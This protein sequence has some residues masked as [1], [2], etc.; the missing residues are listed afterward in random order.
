MIGGDGDASGAIIASLQ[1][2]PVKITGGGEL[3][4]G[5]GINAGSIISKSG[6]ISSVSVDGR[7]L[8]ASGVSG[9]SGIIYAPSGTVKSVH[10]GADLVGGSTGAGEAGFM[11]G[12]IIGENIGTV[13]IDGSLI[14]GHKDGGLGLAGS[15]AIMANHHLESVSIGGNVL[16]N[17]DNFALISAV[18]QVSQGSTSDVGIGKVTIHGDSTFTNILAGFSS[19]GSSISA[20]SQIGTVT[21][22]G[23]WTA[24]NVAAGV[25]RTDA[26]YGNAGDKSI[27]GLYDTGII[28]RISKVILRG[29]IAGTPA[30]GDSFGIVAEQVASVVVNGSPIDLTGGASNDLVPVD[31]GVM[32]NDFHVLEVI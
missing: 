4:G 10:I 29:G 7:V 11:T 24:G 28:S 9:Y 19:I 22:D 14:A 31:T 21:V 20:D 13:R 6:D 16:G 30:P 26:Y 23:T 18:G 1:I 32:T 27:V 8:G 25:Q 17:I 15:G 2:G 5:A 12:A 3:I